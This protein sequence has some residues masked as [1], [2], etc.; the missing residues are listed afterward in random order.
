MEL[1]KIKGA[2]TVAI[3]KYGKNNLTYGADIKLSVSGVEKS[4]IRSSATASRIAQL[5]VI[6]ILFMC[7][8]TTYYEETIE[9]IDE[10]RSF[11]AMYKEKRGNS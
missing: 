9:Y 5:H 7:Y 8:A 1:A 11:V 10:T 3:T 6:D 4:K 2:T